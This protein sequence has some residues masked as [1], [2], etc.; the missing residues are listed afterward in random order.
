[1]RYK[2]DVQYTPKKLGRGTVKFTITLDTNTQLETIQVLA[3]LGY[4]YT[5]IDRD[6]KQCT[7][8]GE[9]LFNPQL[10][11]NVQID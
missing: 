5:P 6:F 7:A 4:P 10:P 1:M 8:K 2:K 9:R 3:A 11:L